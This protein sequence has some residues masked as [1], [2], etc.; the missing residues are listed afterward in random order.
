MADRK[1][2]SF[3]VLVHLIESLVK[4]LRTFG[5]RTHFSQVLQYCVVLSKLYPCFL[6]ICFNGDRDWFC[7]SV[8]TM[9]KV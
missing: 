7:S 3:P 9:Y 2:I 6:S 5:V 4:C 1:L 8:V